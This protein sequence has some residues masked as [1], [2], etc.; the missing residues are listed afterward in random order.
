MLDTASLFVIWMLSMSLAFAYGEH[1]SKEDRR[2][3][4]EWEQREWEKRK[5]SAGTETR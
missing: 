1:R 4:L 5:V 3:D 2:K